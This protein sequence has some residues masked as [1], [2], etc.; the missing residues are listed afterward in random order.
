MEVDEKIHEQEPCFVID[1]GITK[2]GDIIL[3]SEYALGSKSIR[4][5][6]LGDYS[7][8]MINV[9]ISS[10]IH[11]VKDKGVEVANPQRKGYDRAD[12][13][14]VLRYQGDNQVE[15][16]TRAAEF[17][18]GQVGMAYSVPQAVATK[19]ASRRTQWSNRQFC[20]RLVAQA[21]SHAGVRLVDD[22]DYCTPEDLYRS[23]LLVIVP[24]GAREANDLDRQ[25][26]AEGN[27]QL[28]YQTQIFK[29][30]LE[31]AR[32]ITGLD[33]QTPDQIKLHLL[34]SDEH[35]QALTQSLRE[36]GFLTLWKV[37]VDKNPW[38]YDSQEYMGIDL[39]ADEL[40]ESAEAEYAAA[41]VMIDRFERN[42]SALRHILERADR[43]YFRAELAL[44]EFLIELHSNRRQAA[45]AVLSQVNERR[46]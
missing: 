4:A 39:P 46:V 31:D 42:A 1:T 33:L 35:D 36:S 13:V 27:G 17:V 15:V 14:V 3:T 21:Y 22:P 6:T 25:L 32:R 19:L 24:G 30:H 44:Y 37:D 10:Y 45:L 26:I 43:C 41:K 18:R 23:A 2:I 12:R 8:A 38:R 5:V 9:G 20:S 29:T 34:Q 7:H 16:A 28:D 11:A 40:R